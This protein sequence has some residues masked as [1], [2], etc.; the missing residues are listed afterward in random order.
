MRRIVVAVAGVM[1]CLPAG[2]TARSAV[3]VPVDADAWVQ[4]GTNSGTNYGSSNS[5][6]V[7][8]DAGTGLR[9][10]R[11]TYLSFDVSSINGAFLQSAELVL[12]N[13]GHDFHT[14]PPTFSSITHPV[15]GI[16]DNNDWNPATLSEASITWDN[17]PQNSTGSAIGFLD[18]GSTSSNASRELDTL[19]ITG[20]DAVGTE[21]R[22][23]VTEYVQWALG[24]NSSF[25]SFATQDSDGQ[26]TF[27][28]AWPFTIGG[29]G[30]AT[31]FYSSEGSMTQGPML[32][33]QIIP[34]PSGV[35][36]LAIGALGLIGH[37]R[38]R[39]R[40]SSCSDTMSD[41]ALPDGS[42]EV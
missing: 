24:A 26:I 17:A 20:A 41:S 36:L 13:R 18:Q 23:D 33:L 30:G 25:S 35:M 27:M 11:K 38:R 16:I 8:G 15:Y 31:N 6:L 12:A 22:F 10:A 28:I 2:Q 19:S 9:F 7:K 14:F 3:I 1:L 37:H 5:L 34:E 32:D 42:A 40:S 29:G 39:R 4:G 21:Y